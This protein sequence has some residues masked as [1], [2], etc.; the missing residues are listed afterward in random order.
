VLCTAMMRWAAST[1]CI[2]GFKQPLI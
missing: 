2:T 1:A